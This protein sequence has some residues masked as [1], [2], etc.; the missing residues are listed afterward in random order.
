MMGL[1]QPSFMPCSECGAS[2]AV[3]QRDLHVCDPERIV[4]HRMLKLRPEVERF[5]SEL[6][7]YLRTPQG[8]F[9]TWYAAHR[10]AA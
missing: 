9:E 5:E 8:R 10:R 6:E 3:A 7:S 2:V 4:D 1:P